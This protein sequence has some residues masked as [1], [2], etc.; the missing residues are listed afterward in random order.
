MGFRILKAEIQDHAS[1]N[2]PTLIFTLNSVF[3]TIY[4]KLICH[5]TMIWYYDV[6]THLTF[7]ISHLVYLFFAVLC[8][9]FLVLELIGQDFIKWFSTLEL[10]LI[11]NKSWQMFSH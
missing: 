3:Q 2:P 5:E 10:L 6:V 11:S 1:P 7:I 8:H 9:W 4:F